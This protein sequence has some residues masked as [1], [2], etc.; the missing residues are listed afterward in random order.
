MELYVGIWHI[1][2]PQYM[3]YMEYPIIYEKWVRLMGLYMGIWG[4]FPTMEYPL[5]YMG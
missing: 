1:E 2:Y 4:I 3:E 5:F